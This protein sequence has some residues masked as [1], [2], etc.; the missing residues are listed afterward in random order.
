M[1]RIKHE[2][3]IY[4]LEGNVMLL[5]RRWNKLVVVEML[6]PIRII[7]W[8]GGAGLHAGIE[9]LTEKEEI[10]LRSSVCLRHLG[11]F[12]DNVAAAAKHSSD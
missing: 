5:Q 8:A 6:T 12:D 4:R 9:N 7:L 2:Q 3:L 10:Y 11:S 1:L